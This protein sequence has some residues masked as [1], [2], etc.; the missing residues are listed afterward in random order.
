[1][2]SFLTATQ[3][4][5]V[6]LAPDRFVTI[7]IFAAISGFTE[8]A[9]RRKIESGVWIERREYFIER[10]EYFRSPD[11]HIFIDREGVQKWVMRGV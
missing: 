6:F 3:P 4:P 1:M 2:D 5:P 8:K 11:S 10:R 7:K 9:I